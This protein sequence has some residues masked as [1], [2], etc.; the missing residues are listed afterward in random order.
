M[1]NILNTIKLVEAK[2]SPEPDYDDPS[3]DEKVQ[4]IG[5]KAKQAEL[6]KSKGKE[7][8]TRWNPETKKY[9]VDFSDQ[10]DEGVNLSPDQIQQMFQ[11][12]ENI[13]TGAGANRSLLGKTKDWMASKNQPVTQP[14]TTRQYSDNPKSVSTPNVADQAMMARQQKQAQ[15]AQ[16]ARSGMTTKPTSPTAALNKIAPKRIPSKPGEIS[17]LK[18]R[19]SVELTESQIFRL[20]GKIVEQQKQVDE[21][22]MDW[23]RTKGQN[24]T[25]KITAD[26]LLQAW[27]RAGSKTDS[28]E[29]AKVMTGAGVPQETVNNLIK[30]FVQGAASTTNTNVWQGVDRSIPPGQRKSQVQPATNGTASNIAMPS[31][32]TPTSTNASVT[33]TITPNNVPKGPLG[34]KAGIQAVNQAVATVKKVKSNIRPE[35]AK[36][37]EEQFDKISWGGQQFKPGDPMYDKMK[38]AAGTNE[39]VGLPYPSTY[40]ET[41]DM[42]KSSGQRRIGSLTT[43]DEQ[44]DGMAQGEIRAIIKNAIHIKNQLDKGVSLDGWMYS[45]VTT[46]NDHLNSVAEQI[47]NPN[48]DEQELDEACWKGYHKEGNKKMFGKTYPNCVKNE[49]VAEGSND[50]IYPNAEVIKSKNGKPIGEIYQDEYGWGC[51]HYKAD[52]GADGMS[53]REEALEQ[54]KDMHNE[55]RQQGVAESQHSESCPHCGGEMVSEELMNEKKDACYYKVKSR[56]KVWPSAYASGALVKCRKKGASNWGTG[57][58]SNESVEEGAPELLKQEMPLVRHIEQELAQH[59]YK[60]GT[61]EYDQMFKHTMSMYRKFGNVDAIKRGVAEGSLEEVSQDTARSYAQ[62][63]RASQKDLI[64]QTHRKGADTDALNKKIKNRQQG[65]DRAHTDKR[66]YKDEQG[67]AEGSESLDYQGNCTEDDVVDDIF[68]DVNNFANMVEKYGD[69]FTRGN[70]VVKYDPK[71]DVHYF[72]YKKQGVAEAVETPQQQQVRAAISKG[73]AVHKQ[74]GDAE[75]KTR[76]DRSNK[77]GTVPGYYF[78]A[79][80]YAS[81][82]LTGIDSIDPDGTVVISLQDT[83]AEG[84]VKKLAALGGMPGVKTR[85]LKMTFDPLKRNADGKIQTT[86]AEEW[87]QKYKS[88]INCSHP[89]GFSQKAHCAGKQKNESSILEGIEQVDENLHKWFKEKWVRF[90]PDGKIR[91]ACARGDDSEGKPKCLPQSKAHSL[92]K[93]G[94]ASAAAR[95]RREDPNPE[96][97]G[98]A[99]NVNTKKK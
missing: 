74:K 84:W 2:R 68:G 4:N 81:D 19:E 53:N 36:Y 62:K 55:R 46:S 31:D 40:E 75:Y 6:L 60:K 99:I 67:V 89:K 57:G 66:Y 59:G 58:K 86:V 45:Y 51:L 88:S 12:A 30:S 43:E 26:K 5:Q 17:G 35:V 92:G 16:A 18:M 94:R 34:K 82:K 47:N 61:P 38:A 37:G 24:L 27:K 96:R 97:H 32:W 7:P 91:G 41:N 9:Y 70:L 65:M 79:T 56:Y 50:T 63:A 28:D 10:V 20:I 11:G 25:N 73:L 13:E 39:S 95:K 90:G 52:F 42:F 78:D 21:G 85:Q 33:S 64:N 93:K 48:I 15:A 87:S 8:R 23:A 22:V 29:V 1:S 54:L 72:Y 71:K 69:E 98:K 14:V 3:W 76:L 44:I 80:G 83:D 77:V 49:G